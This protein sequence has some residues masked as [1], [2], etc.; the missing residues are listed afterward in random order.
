MK[1]FNVLWSLLDKRE[2][3]KFNV[4]IVLFIIQSFLEV[5]GI[6]S[7]IPFI[8]AIFNPE[9]LSSYPFLRDYTDYLVIYKDKLLVISSIIFFGIFV[10]KNLFSLFTERLKN[11]F[12]NDF[13]ASISK[14]ILLKYLSQDF[15]F[16]SKNRQGKLSNII[17]SETQNLANKFLDPFIIFVSEA[18]ILLAIFLLII[19][20]GYHKGLL[21][22]LPILLFVGF[23]LKSINK[24]I[25]SFSFL[26]VDTAEKMQ[27]L[28][29]RFFIG[30]RDILLS[31]N[32]VN[33]AEKFYLYLKRQADIDS[34]NATYQLFP[35]ALLELAGLF[36]LLVLVIYYSQ[37]GVDKNSILTNLTFY[38][39]IA[40]KAI[41][42]YNKI[43]IQYQK[44][45]YSQNSLNIIK[46]TLSLEDKR[47]LVK[48]KNS[49]SEFRK[50]IELKNLSFSYE[51][52]NKILENVNLKINKGEIIGICGE[53]GSGKSTLL[54]LLTLL[55]KPDEGSFYLDGKLLSENN[56]I[57]GYQDLIRFIS[58]D[59]FLI[60]DNIK[61]NII[62]YSQDEK[63]HDENR[64]EYAIKFSQLDKV[65]DTFPN[66]LDYMVGSHSRRISSGQ[67]QRIAMARAIYNAKDIL[68]F[69][70]ATNALDFET[71]Q[72]IIQ[73][74]YG[75]KNKY[76]VI[77]VSHEMRNL[78]GC[79]VI[80]EVKNKIV[81]RFVK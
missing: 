6:A 57:K 51:N 35:K 31:N 55:I 14:K 5:I 7:V 39:V 40:Y 70:E 75:L 3:T 9:K 37:I 10:F 41:P 64:L 58:Q 23:I 47:S 46:D 80:F 78:K 67:K 77:L 53:S 74:I 24:K 65:I 17:G 49:K 72:K 56:Q 52:G 60:E 81:Q 19:V 42:S 62:F 20:S 76:T 8:T 2:K 45:I 29:Q 30:I 4:L 21:V 38:F 73:N 36:V 69:D 71:E 15:L 54:N 11:F 66:N 68:I 12:I 33:F 32:A 25:K 61:N 28:T 22:I 27:T 48:I 63:H 18:M 13:R 43:L 44:L 1:D 34:N 16:F 59:T 26:R 79:D 50:F